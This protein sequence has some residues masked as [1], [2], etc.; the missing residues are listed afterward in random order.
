MTGASRPGRSRSFPRFRWETLQGYAAIVPDYEELLHVLRERSRGG[1]GA[2]T[3]D[4]ILAHER[5]GGKRREQTRTIELPRPYFSNRSP[6]PLTPSLIPS[7]W[8]GL[9]SRRPQPP[10]HQPDKRLD[11]NLYSCNK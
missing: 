6:L 3:G 5:L 2:G 10:P 7:A 1:L 11:L 8:P 9:A 4:A